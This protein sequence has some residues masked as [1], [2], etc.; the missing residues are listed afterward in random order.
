M[1]VKVGNSTF[2]MP[3]TSIRQ[4]FIIKKED[5]IKDLDNKEMIL[6][7]GECHSIL[8]LHEFYNIKTDRVNIE[9]G[10]VIMVEDQGKTRCIFADALIGEQQ[11][12]IKAL[13]DY[14]KKVNGVSGCSLLGD[15]TISL[16]LDIS[17]IVNL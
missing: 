2:T 12:V 9:D 11:V 1:T 5:V 8:R 4:S 10:I 15:A 13:P 16:I 6:I 7:R 14:I 17:E 3:V